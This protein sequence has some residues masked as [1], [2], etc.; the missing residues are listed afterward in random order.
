MGK[1]YTYE[2]YNN[3]E[4]THYNLNIENSRKL[5]LRNSYLC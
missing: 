2:F 1:F 3:E 5:I 4:L